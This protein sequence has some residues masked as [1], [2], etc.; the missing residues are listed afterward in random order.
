[1]INY[2]K[3]TAK[4]TDRKVPTL[5]R[6]CIAFA[7]ETRAAIKSN[8]TITRFPELKDLGFVYS[9]ACTDLQ[10]NDIV[11]LYMKQLDLV[12]NWTASRTSNP[13]RFPEK[14]ELYYTTVLNYPKTFF[15]KIKIDY[16]N[17]RKITV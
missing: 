6:V 17:S 2:S 15:E 4:T 5:T 14:M 8:P 13:R 11:N 1:L 3:T 12:Q 9:W 16:N 10:E 7:D